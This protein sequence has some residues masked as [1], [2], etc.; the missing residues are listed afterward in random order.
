MHTTI[1]H[2]SEAMPTH[3]RE[4]PSLV[5][6]SVELLSLFESSLRTFEARYLRTFEGIIFRLTL[7]E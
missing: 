4:P 5:R 6:S 1:N 2:P 7:D 3:N